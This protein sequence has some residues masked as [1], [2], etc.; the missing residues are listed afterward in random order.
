MGCECPIAGI[1]NRR[2][3]IKMPAAHHKRCQAGQHEAI[4]RFY[5]R[6]PHNAVTEVS[7]RAKNNRKAARAALIKEAVGAALKERIAKLVT[8]KTSKGCNCNNLAADMDRWG[9]AGCEERREQI[10]DHLVGNRD[11]LIEA[12]RDW[13]GHAAGLAASMIPDMMLRAGAGWLLSNAIDDVRGSLYSDSRPNPITI[14]KH[15]PFTADPKLTLLCH[16]W[17]NGE[18]WRRHVE[19]LKPVDGVFD[20]KIMGVAVNKGSSGFDDVRRAFGDSWE[21]FQVENDKN[22]REVATYGK[23]F[24]MVESIDENDVTFCIHTKGTQDRTAASQQIR[25]WTEA[26]YETVIYDWQTVLEKMEDGYSIAGSFRRF[27]A[28]FQ[29]RYGW[30]FSGTFYAFRNAAT[31]QHGIPQIDQRWWGT[32]SWPGRHFCREETACMFADNAGDIYKA[33]PKL[34]QD[35]IEWRQ[36]NAS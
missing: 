20:R 7:T 29:T 8:I 23:M 18:N 10:I 15:R 4:D 11:M 16:C 13:L 31:F 34:E 32:E 14:L 27:G 3:G 24:Q 36:Q 33:D 5:A 2:G 30:H 19:Y 9:I 25:W 35:L 1:C 26:M 28:H 17:A 6:E 21:Y 22:L 12:L